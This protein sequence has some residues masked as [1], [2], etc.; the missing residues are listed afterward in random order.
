M[1]LLADEHGGNPRNLPYV[2][3]K[4]YKHKVKALER[5]DVSIHVITI[6]FQEE[7]MRKPSLVLLNPSSSRNHFLCRLYFGLMVG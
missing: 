3:K 4:C 2:Q 5:D 7:T 6:K 1:D